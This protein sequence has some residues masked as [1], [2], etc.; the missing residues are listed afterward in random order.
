[1]DPHVGAWAG[2]DLGSGFPFPLTP[3][4]EASSPPLLIHLTAAVP[5]GS[6]QCLRNPKR[7]WRDKHQCSYLYSISF[8]ALAKLLKWKF[9]GLGRTKARKAPSAHP[10]LSLP[11]LSQL[12]SITSSEAQT[13]ATTLPMGSDF[14]GQSW[15]VG[16]S[17]LCTLQLLVYFTGSPACQEVV[18]K[19][20]WASETW[21]PSSIY[22]H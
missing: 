18:A 8:C 16:G 22:V 10:V 19:Q 1:M 11:F 15:S 9:S 3:R 13:P 7:W 21:C 5:E 20:G 2:L 17:V 14:Q 12:R 4:P 6:S